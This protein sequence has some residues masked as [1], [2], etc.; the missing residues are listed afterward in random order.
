VAEV[1]SV[2]PATTADDKHSLSAPCSL[3]TAEFL[4]V[5]PALAADA[6][7]SSGAFSSPIAAEFPV[8]PATAEITGVRDGFAA[9]VMCSPVLGFPSIGASPVV[10]GMPPAIFGDMPPSAEMEGLIPNVFSEHHHEGIH[11]APVLK[12][13]Y[14]ASQ[15][16]HVSEGV[17]SH[18]SSSDRLLVGTGAFLGGRY[19]EQALISFGGI[20]E[21]NSTVRSSERIRSQFNADDTQMDRTMHHAELKNIGSYQGTDAHSKNNLHSILNDDIIARTVKLGVSLGNSNSE[22]AQT[23]DDIKNCDTSRTLIMLSKNIDEKA[24]AV[25]DTNLST[26][27]HSRLLSNDLSDEEVE[28]DEDI[29]N[30]TLAE[31]KKN[32]KF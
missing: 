13:S 8:F 30:L 26:L 24:G 21:V 23:I 14:S 1:F 19:Y 17:K 7:Q 18:H 2:F 31:I 28:M 9:A 5:V 22:I 3:A 15:F 25:D 16:D 11:L 32:R 10:N 6:R 12:K 29:L 20:P 27:A 4:S